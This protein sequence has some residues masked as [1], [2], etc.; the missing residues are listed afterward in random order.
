MKEFLELT[1]KLQ[2]FFNLRNEWLLINQSEKTFLLSREEIEV[3]VVGNKILISFLDEDG[4]QTWR[5]VEAEIKKEK[6]VLELA[7]NFDKE[8]QKMNL[9]PR[10]LAEELTATVE[11]ARRE[12]VNKV[13]KLIVSSVE[14]TKLMSAKLNRENGRFAELI[15]EK[16]MGLQF[17]VLADVSDSLPP[18][19]L[20]TSAIV[21]LVKIE[22]QRKNSIDEIWILAEK[23]EVKNLQKLHA[24]LDKKWKEKIKLKEVEHKTAERKYD[25]EQTKLVELKAKET[26]GLWRYK[27][28]KLRLAE[29]ANLSN[30]SQEIVELA[31]NEID[32]LFSRN[33]ETLCYLGLPFMRV[34][35]I[36]EREKAWFGIDRNQ[37]ILD[38]DSYDEFYEM[39]ENLKKYRRFASPNKQHAFYKA[40]PE[41]WLESIMRNNV[42]RLDANLILSP[43]YNQ[44]RTSQDK[45]DLLALR[46]DRRLVIVELK[47]AVDR[48]MPFQALD[49]WRKIELQR[50][51][52]KLDK[53][54]LFGDT[55]IIDEPTV[56]YL[57]APTLSYH[58]DLELLSNSI[59]KDIEIFRFDLAE[60]WR[61]NLKVLH[62]RKIS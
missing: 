24:C 62:R 15:I 55:K 49:Y 45:I 52:G 22:K 19:T 53:A 36:L 20:L 38:E 21:L 37:Q 18:E 10:T 57:A 56:I 51:K 39:F 3:E 4:F 11:L 59:T 23:R 43:I 50:R 30:I 28:P 5:I 13:A 16:K 7:R 40:S 27:P 2:D 25:P 29:T 35:H 14:D 58:H 9:I 46:K 33:G 8:K 26:H 44:F 60:N 1:N 54:K 31:P 6:I 34:R 61:K 32:Y 17:A 12:R 48:E 42:K 41:A 47:V